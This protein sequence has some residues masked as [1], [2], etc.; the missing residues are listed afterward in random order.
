MAVACMVNG[1]SEVPEADIAKAFCAF[2]IDGTGFICAEDLI[3]MMAS[4]GATLIFQRPL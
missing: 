3:R 4:I 1:M 2:D